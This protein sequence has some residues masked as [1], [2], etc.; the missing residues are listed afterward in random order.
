MSRFYETVVK[1]DGLSENG[2]PIKVQQQFLIDAL[3]CTEGEAKTVQEVQDFVKGEVQVTS[4]KE[5]KY[6]EFVPYDILQDTMRILRAENSAEEVMKNE[7]PDKLIHYGVKVNY[8]Q[9]QENGKVKKVPQHFMVAAVSVETA[10][11]TIKQYLKGTMAD[12]EVA[13]I[14]ETKIVDVIMYDLQ[15]EVKNIKKIM[16]DNNMTMTVSKG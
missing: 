2:E 1:Y 16:D 7:L 9:T 10:N 6:T 3:S 13:S 8:L 14:V 5:S 15:S 12:L 4:V 11:E